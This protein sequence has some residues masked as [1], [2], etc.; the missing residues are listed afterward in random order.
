LRTTFQQTGLKP[1][2]ER[3]VSHPIL[4]TGLTRQES[5][6]PSPVGS[7][8]PKLPWD[9][10]HQSKQAPFGVMIRRICPER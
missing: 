4:G 8:E 7:G 9:R 10:Q 3:K 2:L 5:P 1:A 6:S